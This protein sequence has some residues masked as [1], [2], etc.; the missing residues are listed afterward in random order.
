MEDKLIVKGIHDAIDGEHPCDVIGM[1]T[2]GHPNSLTN[3]ELH[4][5][6]TMTGIVASDLFD[7]IFG[8][9]MDASVAMAAVILDRNGKVFQDDWL[10][11]APMGSAI[12]FDI[13]GSKAKDED[14]PPPEGA[15]VN[16]PTDVP[17]TNGGVPSDPSLESPENDPSGTGSL[18]T[19]TSAT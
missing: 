18:P 5:I 11:D 3:R 16:T 12:T 13:N 15:S 1:I 8:G 17:E 4:R 7:S 19:A 6:K 14:I 10:W 2:V 9:D